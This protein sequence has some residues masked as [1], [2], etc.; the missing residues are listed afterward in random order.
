MNIFKTSRGFTLVEIMIVVAIIAV[1][2]TIAV[3]AWTRASYQARNTRFINDAKKFADG[4]ELFASEKNYYP[5]D[6]NTGNIPDGLETYI[7]ADA[8]NLAVSPDGGSSIGGWWD[9]ETNDSGVGSAVGVVTSGASMGLADDYQ[10]GLLEA[11]DDD[12]DFDTGSF[13]KIRTGGYYFVIS[14]DEVLEAP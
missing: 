13:R 9:V 11:R 2:V 12:D 10:L 8:W 5:E 6:G 4:I 7:D 1:L 3:P 14:D